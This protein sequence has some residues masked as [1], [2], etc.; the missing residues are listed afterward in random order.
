MNS[1]VLLHHLNPNHHQGLATPP[2]SAPNQHDYHLQTSLNRITPYDISI[3]ILIYISQSEEKVEDVSKFII[4]CIQHKHTQMYGNSQ[5]FIHELRNTEISHKY[6]HVY[7]SID[8][9]DALFSF[10]DKL[11]EVPINKSSVFGV[12]LR[13]TLLMFNNLLFDG[14][15]TLYDNILK[16]KTSSQILLLNSDS[17][18]CATKLFGQKKDQT[19]KVSKIFPKLYYS[20]YIQ[21]CKELDFINANFNIHIYY[22]YFQNRSYSALNKSLLYYHFKYYKQATISLKESIKIAQQNNEPECLLLSLII[23]YKIKIIEYFHGELNN[24]EIFILQALKFSQTHNNISIT[25]Y[26]L[27]DYIQFK[28]LTGFNDRTIIQQLYKLLKQCEHLQQQNSIDLKDDSRPLL[29]TEVFPKTLLSNVKAHFYRIIG[30]R[31]LYNSNCRLSVIKSQSIGLTKYNADLYSDYELLSSKTIPMADTTCYRL[32]ITHFIQLKDRENVNILMNQFQNLIDK[33]L[34]IDRCDMLYLQSLIS[35]YIDENTHDSITKLVEC[36]KLAEKYN[37]IQLLTVYLSNCELLK[38]KETSPLLLPYL[39][40]SIEYCEKNGFEIYKNRC[41]MYLYKDVDLHL[42]QNSNLI[43]I[44]GALT[45]KAYYYEL[46]GSKTNNVEHLKTALDC[47]LKSFCLV[48]S[49]QL[50]Y[51]LANLTKDVFYAK[52]YCNIHKEWKK[53]NPELLQ[54]EQ[55]LSLEVTIERSLDHFKSALHNVQTFQ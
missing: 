1:S 25:Y 31:L 40:K 49:Q 16:F 27:L 5:Q 9:I 43:P 10:M 28:L 32:L 29:L 6:L 50:S 44:H 13:K 8:S 30:D 2:Q 48:K 26:I 36:F 14:V 52:L 35:F 51:K 42:V 7:N 38:Q 4:Q 17:I 15:K 19:L 3:A 33:S 20:N 55:P 47:Y 23:L 37:F 24:V 21:S 39:L 54:N 45:D 11:K 41:L 46:L 18:E 12:F 53:T 34:T 22:D